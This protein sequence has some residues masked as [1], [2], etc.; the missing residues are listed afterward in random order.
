M[1]FITKK[2]RII[3][4]TL[5]SY[6]REL[7]SKGILSL[8]YFNLIDNEAIYLSSSDEL[9]VESLPVFEAF[10][11]NVDVCRFPVCTN[12]SYMNKYSKVSTS[13][14]GTELTINRFT[15]EETDKDP[16]LMVFLEP[17]QSQFYEISS[18]VA[19][20]TTRGTITDNSASVMLERD[21][22]DEKARYLISIEVSSSEQRYPLLVSGTSFGFSDDNIDSIRYSSEVNKSNT[23][24]EIVKLT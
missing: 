1:A 9:T 11:D 12:K 13:V 5:S 8:K 17:M 14:S 20:L 23:F 3:D 22:S 7:L 18:R 16:V 2:D 24:Y 21:Y 4:V 15:T 6:G 10:Y 19:S